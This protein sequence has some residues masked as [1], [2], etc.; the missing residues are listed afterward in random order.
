MGQRQAGRARDGGGLRVAAGLDAKRVMRPVLAAHR[1]RRFRPG[2][3][4]KAGPIRFA[5]TRRGCAEPWAASDV[6]LELGA[7]RGNACITLRHQAG[8]S[9]T[10][11]VDQH[12]AL[13]AVL[14]P[15]GGAR[16]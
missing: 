8:R 16:W 12:V 4:M 10:G 6:S 7:D 13:E 3:A 2:E 1:D 14:C 15:F 9:T 11:P 5:W